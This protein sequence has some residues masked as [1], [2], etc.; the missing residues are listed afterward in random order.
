[1]NE[2]GMG[3]NGTCMDNSPHDNPQYNPSDLIR[4][5]G[6]SVSLPD[7]TSSDSFYRSYESYLEYMR[8][9]R[10][11]TKLGEMVWYQ[12]KAGDMDFIGFRT[13]I[14]VQ[15]NALMID[16]YKD[17]PIGTFM[18]IRSFRTYIVMIGLITAYRMLEQDISGIPWLNV[19]KFIRSMVPHS[20][21]LFYEIKAAELDESFRKV[22]R[23]K[24]SEWHDILKPVI[25]QLHENMLS[26]TNG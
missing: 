14:P 5:Y 21:R 25:E 10:N 18:D 9:I 4:K 11:L 8:F 15:I 26:E 23:L 3:M 17:I 20:Q 13:A 7:V 16:L 2:D 24:R 22:S 1:M 19:E 6:L 12:K